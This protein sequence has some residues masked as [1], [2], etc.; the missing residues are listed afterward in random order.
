[1]RDGKIDFPY[2]TKLSDVWNLA[3]NSQNWGGSVSASPI[4]GAEKIHD[5]GDFLALSDELSSSEALG[6]LL[7]EMAKAVEDPRNNAQLRARQNI[8]KKRLK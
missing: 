4:E 7:E 1:M 5:H 2:L 8:L 3:K 6:S